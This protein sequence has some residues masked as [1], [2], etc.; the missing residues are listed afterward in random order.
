ML[1]LRTRPINIVHSW[2]FL[3]SCAFTLI[4]TEK[5]DRD[6]GA[7]ADDDPYFRAILE[8]FSM[9][10]VETERLHNE[11]LKQR[12]EHLQALPTLKFK[13]QRGERKQKTNNTSKEDCG[14][15]KEKPKPSSLPLSFPA[16]KK[17]DDWIISAKNIHHQPPIVGILRSSKSFVILLVILVNL[18]QENKQFLQNPLRK[19]QQSLKDE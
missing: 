16:F 8:M 6:V 3:Y 18:E 11:R 19:E 9:N 12:D 7:I 5:V 1:T 17:D 15:S 13:H 14:Q 4:Q 2:N 10:L